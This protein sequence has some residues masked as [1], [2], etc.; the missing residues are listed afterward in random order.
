[1]I[2]L[3][4]GSEFLDILDQRPKLLRKSREL[5]LTARVLLSFLIDLFFSNTRTL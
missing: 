1:M 3:S 5:A 4:I 2:I